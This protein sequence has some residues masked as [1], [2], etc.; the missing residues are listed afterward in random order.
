ML[1]RKAL[2][3]LWMRSSH[4]ER[5]YR[6]ATLNVT[7][8]PARAGEAGQAERLPDEMDVFEAEKIEDD[9]EDTRTEESIPAVSDDD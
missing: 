9:G 1:P 4:S 3:L 5:L 8:E 6:I 7:I 2:P